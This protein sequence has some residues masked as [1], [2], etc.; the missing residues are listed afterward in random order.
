[1]AQLQKFLM[2]QLQIFLFL[3]HYRQ[4]VGTR[5]HSLKFLKGPVLCI[6]GPGQSGSACVW[7]GV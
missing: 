7:Q 5:A 1:M 3:M 2:A 6:V 4:H